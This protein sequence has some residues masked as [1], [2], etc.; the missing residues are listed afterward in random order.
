MIKLFRFSMKPPELPPGY[1]LRWQAKRDTA[2]VNGVSIIRRSA[3]P[4]SAV[5]A[6]LCRRSPKKHPLKA[7]ASRYS[8]PKLKE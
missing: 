8:E 7:D 2:L 1:G 5:A 6:A 3:N 4:K